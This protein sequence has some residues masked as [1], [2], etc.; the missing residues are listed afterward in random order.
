MSDQHFLRCAEVE[1]GGSKFVYDGTIPDNIADGRS[2]GPGLRIKFEVHQADRS[3]PNWARISIFNVSD[4]AAQPALKVGAEVKLSAGYGGSVAQIFSGQVLQTRTKV[5]DTPADPNHALVILAQD[6][7][8]A[9]NFAVA[10]KT[11]SKGHTHLDRVKACLEPMAALGVSIGYLDETVLSKT[12]FPRGI[13]LF[14]ES[15]NLLRSICEGT[16]TSFSIQNGKAQVI[17]NK[18]TL[19]GG[20][21]TLNG[22]TG[23][24]GLPVQT[25]QGI[26]ARMQLNGLLRPGGVVVIDSKDIQRAEFSPAYGAAGQNAVQEGVSIAADGRY[27]VYVVEHYGDT[28]G[29]TFETAIVCLSVGSL[30]NAALASRGIALPNFQ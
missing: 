25:M 9:R 24:L 30:G 12:K 21:V 15:K 27:K 20:P 1:V 26:E 28:R 11:L 18:G 17:S 6:H 4:A 3:A 13:A 7:G 22:R 16:N 8:I 5:R 14:G 23:L 29:A 19:P 10:N 2:E